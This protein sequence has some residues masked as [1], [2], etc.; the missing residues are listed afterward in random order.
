ML[1][2]APEPLRE[3]RMAPPCA[4]GPRPR[5]AASAEAL[6][7]GTRAFFTGSWRRLSLTREAPEPARLAAA[8]EPKPPCGDVSQRPSRLLRPNQLAGRCAANFMRRFSYESASRATQKASEQCFFSSTRCPQDSPQLVPGFWCFPQD[9]RGFRGGPG[10][11]V[12]ASQERI[13]RLIR[14]N[15]RTRERS[16]AIECF[17]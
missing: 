8:I 3:R 15:D 13:S 1:S 6:L 4:P 12:E 14:A 11:G 5:H 16:M 9:S 17:V 2:A 10:M 7:G